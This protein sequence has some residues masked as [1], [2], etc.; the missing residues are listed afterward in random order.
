MTSTIPSDKLIL[1]SKLKPL[2]LHFPV[3]NPQT[4]FDKLLGKMQ[5]IDP[6]QRKWKVLLQDFGVIP[7]FFSDIQVAHEKEMMKTQH[8]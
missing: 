2:P 7:L 6:D 5:K 1:L 3:L 4:V 8:D